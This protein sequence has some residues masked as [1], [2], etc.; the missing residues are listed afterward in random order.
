MKNNFLF[1]PFLAVM[2]LSFGA[3]TEHEDIPPGN[4]PT[5]PVIPEI[6]MVNTTYTGHV[7]VTESDDVLINYLLK[8]FTNI[9]SKH[10]DDTR[11]VI[12]GEK[13]AETIL[14]DPQAFSE[15]TSYWYKN[16][17][18]GLIRP[19]KNCLTLLKALQL[20]DIEE[21]QKQVTPEMIESQE[22]IHLRIVRTDGHGMDYLILEK[23]HKKYSETILSYD[24]ENNVIDTRNV[25]RS[26]DMSHV[27]SEFEFGRIAE[28]AAEW[29]NEYFKNHTAKDVALTSSEN[30]DYETIMA[31][32]QT[33]IP[34]TIDHYLPSHYYWTAPDESSP[35]PVSVEARATIQVV[36]GYNSVI[37]GDVY[38][39]R[40]LQE[41][42]SANI[43]S[44]IRFLTIHEHLEY[45]W[46]YSGGYY[47]GPSVGVRLHGNENSNFSFLDNS[48]VYEPAPQNKDKEYVVT[49]YPSTTSLGGNISVGGSAGNGGVSA[50]ASGS[51]SFNCT[52]PY[53]TVSEPVNGMPMTYSSNNRDYVNWNFQTNHTL[54]SLHWGFNPDFNEPPA[55]TTGACTNEEAVTFSVVNSKLLKKEPVYID[56]D[57]N[58]KTYHELARATIE[59]YDAWGHVSPEDHY[60]SIQAHCYTIKNHQMPQVYRYFE[61]YT[62]FCFYTSGVVD[63]SSGWTQFNTTL[64]NNDNYRA[65]AED[66]L[67]RAVVEE[68]LDINAER[69]WRDA[70]K[71]LQNRNNGN[72]TSESYIVALADEDDN[73]LSVG[74]YVHDGIWEI[75][76]NIDQLKK[77]LT[78]KAR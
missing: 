39:L 34:I 46:R 26:R 12:L 42:N 31:I 48:S 2:L 18:L 50:D 62:P 53:N 41:Y 55:I 24:E 36:A 45:N 40:L 57:L 64:L 71:S 20:Q 51:F 1:I 74:L 67:I 22:N 17:A 23:Q 60:K 38:D 65:F 69:V 66:Y 33:Y 58:F 11:L 6:D 61:D 52:L 16:N 73:H 5:L 59:D 72:S 27:P 14:S 78:E 63:G 56:L 37:D 29:M 8:R 54:H 19:G 15:Y 3:C 47:Y 35:K 77:E 28:R 7:C 25:D 44:Y 70:L 9:S 75:V 30:K 76:E 21:A 49:H 68:D 32:H 4:D 43:K 10:N 13:H